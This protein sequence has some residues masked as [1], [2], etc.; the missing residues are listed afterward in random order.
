MVSKQCDDKMERACKEK[1][2]IVHGEV[3]QEQM[4]VLQRSIV[5][6]TRT[7]ISF[8]D[9]AERLIREWFCITNIIDME[10][11]KALVSNFYLNRMMCYENTS[12]T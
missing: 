5:G 6:E 4:E 2:K 1:M 7:P 3:C 11:Y 9:I 12:R 10:A 8:N